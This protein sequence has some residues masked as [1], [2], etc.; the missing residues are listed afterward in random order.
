MG[1][2]AAK[3]GIQK[4][5]LH[6]APQE[7]FL[8]FAICS[9]ENCYRLS[10]LI[11]TSLS[12]NLQRL[13]WGNIEPPVELEEADVYLD[14]RAA[15]LHL[16]LPNKLDAGKLLLPKLKQFDFLYAIRGGRMVDE[17]PEIFSKIKRTPGIIAVVEVDALPKT[18]QQLLSQF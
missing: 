9:T 18:V 8:I 7:P 1:N 11:N 14:D 3:R 17:G 12:I 10:W 6:E 5:K 16:L 4:I 2:E 15:E 13:S